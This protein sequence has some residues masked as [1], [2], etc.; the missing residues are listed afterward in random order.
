M[1]QR[2]SCI[3]IAQ[4]K[5]YYLWDMLLW[6]QLRHKQKW[7]PMPFLTNKKI[8]QNCSSDLKYL[9][10]LIWVVSLSVVT[11]KERSDIFFSRGRQLEETWD[12]GRQSYSIWKRWGDICY[13]V[14]SCQISKGD[15]FGCF[16]VS[17][18]TNSEAEKVILQQISQTFSL[19]LICNPCIDNIHDKTFI[20]RYILFTK[21]DKHNF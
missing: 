7:G 10:T 19:N 3:M 11:L 16:S 9:I 12:R 4:I 2:W 18:N 14:L 8:C 13:R 20:E 17:L 1:F 15:G 6:E 5:D 21:Q